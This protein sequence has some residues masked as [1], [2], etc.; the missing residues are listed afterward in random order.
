MNN[1]PTIFSIS[2][3]PAG[4][5]SWYVMCRNTNIGISVARS[6]TIST[7]APVVTLNSPANSSTSNSSSVS[8]NFTAVD[9]LSSTLN[10]SILLDG[11][12]NQ[13]NASTRNNTAT[14]FTISNISNGSHSWYVQCNDNAN[15]GTSVTRIFT[16]NTTSS[17]WA[18]SSFS[19][20][21]NITII[22]ASNTA[23]ANFPALIILP[24][25]SSMQANYSDLRFYNTS[26]NNG[27]ALLPY[28]IENYTSSNATIW[29]GTNLNGANTT[30]S[31]YYKNSTP[32]S[33]GQ[34]ASGVWNSN[35]MGVWH[36]TKV[37]A[38]DS[39]S[40]ANNGVT[41]SSNVSINYTGKISSAVN[42]VGGNGN[43][44]YINC[45]NSSS[46][47]PTSSL[48]LEA[49]VNS[50]STQTAYGKILEKSYTSNSAPYVEYALSLSGVATVPKQ[51]IFELALGGTQQAVT[52]T[53]N[54]TLNGWDYVAAVYNSTAIL[55][56]V[57]GVLQNT[58]AQSGTITS[59]PT[60]LLIG[61]NAYNL[62]QAWNGTID[63]VR[64]S[65]SARS[66][67]WLNQSYQ[68]EL[69]DSKWVRFGVVQSK[70]S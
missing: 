30:I 44:S 50:K 28:E 52:S 4:N 7:R 32:V 65:S 43:N 67:Q 35:F 37:N 40:H 24:Y 14:I 69:N 13:T 45:S 8:F 26:C 58:S 39:T 68:M 16:V 36:M 20:C 31:V 6:F 59:Y 38:T 23:Q 19:Q 12:L 61:A 33:S 1:T 5:H 60:S 3:I 48:T 9:N 18:N 70:P 54:S 2:G 64:I 53:S 62:P 63:E 49:W 27:G 10:C 46:L 21:M 34:N 57:N 22:N 11:I 17:L 56:Y 25:N 55:V 47:N 15:T 29:V 41:K 42:F 66:A 51:Y